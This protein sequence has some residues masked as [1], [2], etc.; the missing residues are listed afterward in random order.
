MVPLT[1]ILVLGVAV[2]AATAVNALYATDLFSEKEQRNQKMINDAFEAQR[3]V[4]AL[5]R[6]GRAEEYSNEDLECE[7]AALLRD[8]STELSSSNVNSFNHS[9]RR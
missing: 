7:L 2:A 8:P 9:Q 3:Q 6:Y 1:Y 5:S 4:E